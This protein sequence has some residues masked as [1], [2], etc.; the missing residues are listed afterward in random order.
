M[1]FY[2]SQI[3]NKIQNRAHFIFNKNITDLN[4]F[5]IQLHFHMVITPLEN[6]GIN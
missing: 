4:F 3:Y 6:K 1:K 2:L 5:N